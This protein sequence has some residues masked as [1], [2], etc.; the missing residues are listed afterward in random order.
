MKNFPSI[1]WK[2][3]CLP[4]A[5]LHDS[6]DAITRPILTPWKNEVVKHGRIICFR[7]ITTWTDVARARPCTPQPIGFRHFAGDA[8]QLQ[9]PDETKIKT[10]NL[11]E[12]GELR[13][14][15]WECGEGVQRSVRM[16]VGALWWGLHQNF[17]RGELCVS[18]I[19]CATLRERSMLLLWQVLILLQMAGEISK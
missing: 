3:L 8:R 14:R 17:G 12:M 4:T 7:K 18:D 5:E 16:P 6:T 11:T 2:L 13:S 9:T 1:A 10:Q 19:S 15:G